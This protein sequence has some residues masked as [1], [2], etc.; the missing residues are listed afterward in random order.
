MDTQ[1]SSYLSLSSLATFQLFLIAAVGAMWTKL[2][3]F[4]RKAV[5][6]LIDYNEFLIPMLVFTHILKGFDI[7]NTSDWL[8]VIVIFVIQ[9]L[10]GAIIGFL[11]SFIN[12]NRHDALRFFIWSFCFPQTL[13]LQLLLIEN[14]APVI[15]SISLSSG[16]AF[17]TTAR[18]RALNYIL[19][20]YIFEH[21]L[22]TT[23]G[24]LFLSSDADHAREKETGYKMLQD[25]TEDTEKSNPK[26]IVLTEVFSVAFVTFIITLILAF[27]SPV[28]NSLLDQGSI[29]YSTLYVSSDLIAKTC[30]VMV[31]FVLG[32]ALPLIKLDA[33]YLSLADH[34]I[35]VVTKLVLFPAIGY[36][37]IWMVLQGCSWFKDPV[38]LFVM[39]IQFSSPTSFGLFKTATQRAQLGNDFLVSMTIQHTA[40][41]IILTLLNATWC[42]HLSA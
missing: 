5:E 39:L 15:E 8:P 22:R 2:K 35:N 34:I 7:T 17:T 42:V 36:L 3:V 29:L 33:C 12:S 9:I 20:W 32:T 18:N 6:G 10:I 37:V 11:L 13:T 23:V 24:S 25:D 16:L 19:V 30:K 4:N 21:V 41:I 38:L 1:F 26:G 31:I 40:A 27:I 14:F 28:K